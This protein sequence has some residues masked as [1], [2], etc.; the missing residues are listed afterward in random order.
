MRLLKR[1]STIFGI[2]VVAMSL[3]AAQPARAGD[4]ADLG[5]L[6]ALIGPPNGSGGLCSFLGMGPSSLFP[7]SSSCPQFPTITQ[8]VLE[9]AGLSTQAPEA[10]RAN[11]AVP[12]GIT[13]DAGN[14]SRPPALNPITAF[15]VDPSI[16]SALNPLAFISARNDN[17]PAAATRLYDAEADTLLYAVASGAGSQPDKIFLFY[18]DLSRT[19]K[20][21]PQ[22]KVAAT[23][24]LP[25]TVLNG[26]SERAV[27]AIL[28]IKPGTAAAPCSTSTVSGNFSGSRAQTLL[29]SSI[30]VNCAIVFGASAASPRSHAIFEVAV[31]LLITGSTDPAYFNDPYAFFSTALAGDDTGFNLGSA[32]LSGSIGIAPTAAPVGGP[33]PTGSPATYPLCADLPHQGEDQELSPAVAAFYAITVGGE[34]LLSA[35]LAPA[36]LK[37]GKPSIVCPAGM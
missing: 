22:G 4:G 34:T 21:F 32:G 20:N 16:L 11:N 37:N 23:V 3:A 25:L 19:N 18:E 35:P 30:G 1:W 26:G 14:P 5:G 2:A 29:A 27:P 8:A 24:S 31:P 12:M 33:P 6:Q 15:P 36:L 9:I 10:V 28:Q 13:V 7:V 17:G